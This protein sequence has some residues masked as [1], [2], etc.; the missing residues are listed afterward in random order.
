[1]VNVKTVN[2]E[3]STWETLI[4]MKAKGK[5]ANM[6]QLIKSLIINQKKMQYAKTPEGE[7]IIRNL[8]ERYKIAL[9]KI[10]PHGGLKV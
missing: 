6:D 4:I 7:A 2:V 5:Y 10:Y 1:M 8:P 9:M 3:D